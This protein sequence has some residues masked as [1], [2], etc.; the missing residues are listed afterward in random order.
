MASNQHD[1]T[2]NHKIKP[3]FT[4]KAYSYIFLYVLISKGLLYSNPLETT[5]STD[6]RGKKCSCRLTGRSENVHT[7][8][9]KKGA[10]KYGNRAVKNCYA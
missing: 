10:M 7:E 4:F 2:K 6:E 3:E 5:R 1:I 9:S 8:N